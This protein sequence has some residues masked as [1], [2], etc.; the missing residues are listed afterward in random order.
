MFKGSEV[1]IVPTSTTGMRQEFLKWMLNNQIEDYS[2]VFVTDLDTSEI[3]DLVDKPNVLSST[4][5]NHMKMPKIINTQQQ[6][7]KIFQVPAC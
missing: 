1:E 5:T 2:K 7:F 4:I 3:K 6:L